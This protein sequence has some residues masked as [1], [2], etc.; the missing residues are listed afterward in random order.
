MYKYKIKISFVSLEMPKARANKPGF[1]IMIFHFIV[2]EN[3]IQYASINDF[4]VWL[5]N[6]IIQ[7]ILIGFKAILGKII[8]SV[9][10]LVMDEAD[11]MLDMGFEP[12]IRDILKKVPRKRQTLMFS[13]TWPQ[14]VI[15][16][17]QLF[18]LDRNDILPNVQ[19][20]DNIL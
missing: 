16:S 8:F 9:F 1:N 4:T 20:D 13:A 5:R 14:E 12:Q 19:K 7:R 10:Y 17:F 3:W 6:R 11:R 2:V 18:Y 15:K